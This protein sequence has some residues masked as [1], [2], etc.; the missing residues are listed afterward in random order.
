MTAHSNWI[1][2]GDVGVRLRK[3]AEKSFVYADGDNASV[4]PQERVVMI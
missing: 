3:A 4:R 1:A 2:A